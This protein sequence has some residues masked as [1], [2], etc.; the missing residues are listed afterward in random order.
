VEGQTT[1]TLNIKLNEQAVITCPDTIPVNVPVE[2]DGSD[3]YLPGFD[4]DRYLWDFDDGFYG[5]GVTVTHTFMYPGQYRVKLGVQA[6]PKNRRDK[7]P[8]LRSNYK[9]VVVVSTE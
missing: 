8:E 3:T 4:D 9:D 7:N 2:F 6:A 1:K 5:E